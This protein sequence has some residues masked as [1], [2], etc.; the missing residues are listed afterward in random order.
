MSASYQTSAAT[1]LSDFSKPALPTVNLEKELSMTVDNSAPISVPPKGEDQ[2]D[3]TDLALTTTL[4]QID[5]ADFP[6]GVRLGMIIVALILSIFLVALDLTI[7]ATAIPRITDQFHSLSQVGWYGSAFFLTVA[8]FQSTWG[9]AYKYFPLKITYMLSIIVFELGSL[10]CGVANSSTTLII[11]RAIAGAGGA[12]LSSGA[13]TII[14]FS[15]PP[16][17]RPAFT[18]ILGATFGIASV[19][20]PLLGGVFTDKLSWRWCCKCL[21]CP[22][23][24]PP[25]HTPKY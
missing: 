17:Q 23:Q 5:T 8:A 3:S 18:G 13:Y 21:S 10:I 9:K 2:Q 24:L 25:T 19:V 4:S 6:H 16:K 12:G 11:G 14:A 20:G 7:V 1:S 22:D 15:A